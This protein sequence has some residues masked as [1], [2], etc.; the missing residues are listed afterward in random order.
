M[1]THFTES[2]VDPVAVTWLESVGWSA[3]RDLASGESGA[4]RRVGGRV[5]PSLVKGS[6]ECLRAASRRTIEG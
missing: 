3:R 5:V 1:S 2:V 6:P 4:E